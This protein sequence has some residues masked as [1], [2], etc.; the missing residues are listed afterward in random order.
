[1]PLSN[2]LLFLA[3]DK[4]AFQ[5]ASGGFARKVGVLMLEEAMAAA[6]RDFLE[7]VLQAAQLNLANDTLLAEIPAGESRLIAPDLQAK[8]PAQ[9]LIFGIP[10]AQLGLSI[11]ISQYH[12]TPFLGCTWLFADNLSTLAADVTKKKQLWSALQQMFL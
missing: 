9:L 7:K 12:P 6:N 8:K 10:P 1:M 5:G 2:T 3:A 11:E 4:T